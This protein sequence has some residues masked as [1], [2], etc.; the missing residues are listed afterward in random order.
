MD[1]SALNA[2]VIWTL[3]NPEWNQSSRRR[4]VFLRELGI[5]LATPFVESARNTIPHLSSSSKRAITDMLS[6]STCSS[7]PPSPTLQVSS[8]GP[9]KQPETQ[10]RGRC[11]LC[12]KVRRYIMG[13]CVICS[14]HVCTDHSKK[15]IVCKTCQN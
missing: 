5:A 1:I 12:T 7:F 8:P 15:D 4:T 2:Y 3:L 6:Q 14:N 10:S 13:K 11:L 9:Q